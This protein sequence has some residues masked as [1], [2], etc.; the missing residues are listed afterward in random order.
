LVALSISSACLAPASVPRQSFPTQSLAV[1]AV[2]G[3]SKE[4]ASRLIDR[5]FQSW[6]SADLATLE[7]LFHLDFELQDGIRDKRAVIRDREAL[8][9]YLSSRFV[10]TDRFTE[11]AVSMPERPN[12][13]T[14]NPTVAFKRDSS[15]DSLRGNA[16]LVCSGGRL[17]Q[18]IM[19]SE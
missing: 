18:V 8:R 7:S 6:N 19:S 11:L 1:E 3:C 15:E 17:L 14:A 9:T 4:T 2:A 12:P 5:F 16:K 10:A 13:A